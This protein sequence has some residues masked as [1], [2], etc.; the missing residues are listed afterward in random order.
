MDQDAFFWQMQSGRLP[1]PRCAA[2]LGIVIRKVSPDEGTIEVEFKCDGPYP[3][4]D[5]KSLSIE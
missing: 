3:V 5:N 2:T 4:G 1:P